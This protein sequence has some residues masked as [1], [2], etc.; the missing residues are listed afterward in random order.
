M[1][2]LPSHSEGLPNV[3]LE[4][5]ATRTPILSTFVGGLK[6]VL[7]DGDNALLFKEKNAEDLSKKIIKLVNDKVLREHIS[8]NAY[9]EV[10]QKY[11][12]EIIRRQFRNILEEALYK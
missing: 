4:A 6:E 11:D 3:I 1:L 10:V 2:I 9:R 8:E 7:R 5:M 12:V